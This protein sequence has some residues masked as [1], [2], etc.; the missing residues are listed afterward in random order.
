MSDKCPNHVRRRRGCPTC[1]RISAA[2][3]ESSFAAPHG[4]ASP[5]QPAHILRE[6]IQAMEQ[7]Q[8]DDYCEYVRMCGGTPISKIPASRPVTPNDQAQRPALGGK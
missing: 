3:A 6:A 1:E 8:Y 2:L 5:D 4:S 7:E